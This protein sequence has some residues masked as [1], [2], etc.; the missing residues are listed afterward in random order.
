MNKVQG[1]PSTW[2]EVGGLFKNGD[3]GCWGCHRPHRAGSLRR[4]TSSHL[5]LAVRSWSLLQLLE[6]S[7]LSRWTGVCWPLSSQEWLLNLDLPVGPGEEAKGKSRQGKLMSKGVEL[8]DRTVL[9]AH[10]EWPSSPNQQRVCFKMQIPRLLPQLCS[11]TH[12]GSWAKELAFL[13]S[14][15][16]ENYSHWLFKSPSKFL[17]RRVIRMNLH[18]R[19]VT[20][21]ATWKMHSGRRDERKRY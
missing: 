11:I 14:T 3:C 6:P 20:G 10:E 15:L 1:P 8:P 9:I 17:N 4:L 12:S 16:T 21:A 18:F 2:W 5:E 19:W 13:I 7:L